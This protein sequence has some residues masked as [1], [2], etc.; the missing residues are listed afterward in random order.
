MKIISQTLKN[1]LN[2]NGLNSEYVAKEA[3]RLIRRSECMGYTIL[4][5]TRPTDDGIV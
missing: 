1:N 5:Y 4:Y 2:L 3:L